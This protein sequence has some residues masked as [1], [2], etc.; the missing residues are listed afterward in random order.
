MTARLFLLRGVALGKVVKIKNDGRVGV[1]L[2]MTR[3]CQ[4]ETFI[5]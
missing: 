2:N 4:T 3:C 1:K 5:G